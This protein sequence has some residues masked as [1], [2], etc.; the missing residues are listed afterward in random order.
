MKTVWRYP[1]AAALLY[2]LAWAGSALGQS[3]VLPTEVRGQPNRWIIVAPIKAPA[4]PK[5]VKW[6]AS[7]ELQEVRLDLIFPAAGQQLGRV[8]EAPKAG[9]FKVEA[10]VDGDSKQPLDRAA[11]LT[12][13]DDASLSAGRKVE[14][15]SEL[16]K[17]ISSCRIVVGD[18]PPQPLPDP[19]VKPEPKP[20][21]F[22]P[23][24][25]RVLLVHEAQEKAPAFFDARSVKVYLDS[26]CVKDGTHPS[27]RRIDKD[28]P[29]S[30]LPEPLKLL[31][32]AAKPKVTAYPA[33]VIAVNNSVTIH[34]LPKDEAALIELLQQSGGK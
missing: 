9:V 12:I 15:A 3:V 24:G 31:W 5:V 28:Q 10:W 33:V 17:G 8:Y 14:M 22:T 16:L 11:V 4:D 18:P 21:P 7:P 23:V 1:A 20:D 6:R 19:K 27:W 2:L 34:A 29:A 32:E 13:L 25:F 30:G 26:K